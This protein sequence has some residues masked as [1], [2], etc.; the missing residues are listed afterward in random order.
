MKNVLLSQ[1]TGFITSGNLSA[2]DIISSKAC[3]IVG[4]VIGNAQLLILL[5]K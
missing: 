1:A 3:K 2:F 5:P 4:D